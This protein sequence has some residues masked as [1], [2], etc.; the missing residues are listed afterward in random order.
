[1]LRKYG[2]RNL[3]M[4]FTGSANEVTSIIERVERWSL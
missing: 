2:S 1:M 4:E 3:L